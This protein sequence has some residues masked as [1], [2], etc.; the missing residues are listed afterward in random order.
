MSSLLDRMPHGLVLV[1]GE[2]GPVVWANRRGA[3]LL[4]IPLQQ[5]LGMMAGEVRTTGEK[6]RPL[7]LESGTHTVEGIR[8]R[9]SVHRIRREGS[10]EIAYTAAVL[11]QALEI[12][13]NQAVATGAFPPPAILVDE[14]VLRIVILP[15]LEAAVVDRPRLAKRGGVRQAN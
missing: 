5:L 3:T 11:A 2:S 6:G 1:E 15:R 7:L 8:V 10:N 14:G 4:N 9:S 12:I 13:L